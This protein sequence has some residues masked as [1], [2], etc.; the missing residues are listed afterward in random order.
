[1]KRTRIFWLFLALVHLYLSVGHLA[2][3]FGGEVT[4]THAWKG[5]GALAGFFIM[6][7]FAGKQSRSGEREVATSRV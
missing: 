4:W 7:I 3:F 2:S 5:F 6:L 1:M